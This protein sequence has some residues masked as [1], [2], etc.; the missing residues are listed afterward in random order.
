MQYY[1]GSAVVVNIKEYLYVNAIN[2]MLFEGF[3]CLFSF[4]RVESLFVGKKRQG[5]EACC[6]PQFFS[7]TVVTCV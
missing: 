3:N 5:Q 4:Y 6:I 2:A 1:K 7:V